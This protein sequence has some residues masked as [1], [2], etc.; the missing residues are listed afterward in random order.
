MCYSMYWPFIKEHQEAAIRIQR[1]MR[2]VW[3]ERKGQLALRIMKTFWR[4]TWASTHIQRFYRGRMD[5]WRWK[6]FLKVMHQRWELRCWGVRALRWLPT[7]L[8]S[9]WLTHHYTSWRVCT[10][11][12][13]SVLET[14][15]VC[16]GGA[17]SSTIQRWLDAYGVRAPHTIWLLRLV[18]Q[19][20]R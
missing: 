17:V 3:A 4:R 20:H 16:S 14:F 8:Q 18:I 7:R 11:R 15:S 13:T 5:A 2:R 6:Q 10:T 12:G 1:T 9:C 19:G